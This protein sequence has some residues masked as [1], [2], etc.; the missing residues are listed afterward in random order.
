[1]G[2]SEDSRLPIPCSSDATRQIQVP[3]C[4]KIPWHFTIMI[5]PVIV[6]MPETDDFSANGHGLLSGTRLALLIGD[7]R[8]FS[9]CRRSS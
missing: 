8:A 5:T 2:S 3:H 4:G 6:K 1:L 9:C 7:K